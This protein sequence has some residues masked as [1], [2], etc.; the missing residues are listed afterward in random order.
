MKRILF[1][2]LILSTVVLS[3]CSPFRS[4]SGNSYDY[5][6]YESSSSVYYPE[7]EGMMGGDKYMFD[8]ADNISVASPTSVTVEDRKI[9]KTGSLSL[10]VESVQDMVPVITALVEGIGGNVDSSNITRG[11]NSYSAN[12]T[13]RVPSDQFDSTMTSLKEQAVYVDSEYTNASDVTEYYTDLETR[14]SNKQAEEAQYLEILK[15]ATTVTDILSVTQYLSNVRYEIE[16][17]Q[18]QLKSYDNQID[19]STITLYLSEDE[20]VS[21]VSQT[22]K[23][24]STLRQAA[25]DWVVFLQSGVDGVIYLVIFGWPL[26]IVA[27]GVRRWL[28]RNRKP[29]RK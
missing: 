13:V 3:A 15:Q 25:S 16:S 1:S 9:I 5:D 17:L 12:L 2:F 20:S 21:A 4:M 23:P 26:L 19:K 7:S 14:L 10:H 8:S 6:D 28:R 22:W 29:V 11:Y 24:L 27:W 18:G